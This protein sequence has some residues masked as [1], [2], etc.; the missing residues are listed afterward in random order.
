MN[1]KASTAAYLEQLSN[2]KQRLIRL[3]LIFLPF[4]LI[5]G[6]IGGFALGADNDL[7]KL[8]DLQ[9]WLKTLPILLV[10]AVLCYGMVRAYYRFFIGTQEDELKE[11]LIRLDA[12]NE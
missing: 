7:S 1:I 6:F 8:S 11:V 12:E 5:I 9:F 2:Y 10:A 4:G 3:S